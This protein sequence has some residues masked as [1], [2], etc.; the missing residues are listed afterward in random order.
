MQLHLIKSDKIYN[1]ILETPIEKKKRRNFERKSTSSFYK[2]I[3]KT[4]YFF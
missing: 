1:E 4:T 3:R 2:K